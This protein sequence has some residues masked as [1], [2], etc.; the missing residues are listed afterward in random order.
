MSD[1]RY[2]PIKPAHVPLSQPAPSPEP[3]SHWRALPWVGISLLGL[4]SVALIVV[5]LL[6]RWI[7][8]NAP[9][10]E[11]GQ[12]TTTNPSNPAP[13]EPV[14]IP[15][16][17]AEQTAARREAQAVLTRLM[18]LRQDLENHGVVAWAAVP[19]EQAQALIADADQHYRQRG[20]VAALAQYQQAEQLL[21]QVQADQTTYLEQALEDGRS[22]L[23]AGEADA[24][25]R[26][27]ELALMM[28]PGN[29]DALQGQVRLERLPELLVALERAEEHE[30][31]GEL[32][33]ALTTFQEALALDSQSATAQQGRDRLRE[34]VTQQRYQTALDR[35]FAALQAGDDTSAQQAFREALAA[36]PGDDVARSGLA[37]AEDR[38]AH[39]Q[40]TAALQRARDLEQQESWAEAEQ[41]YAR[42]QQSDSSLVEARVG[43]MRAAARAQL[44][45]DIEQLLSDPL[46]LGSDA[47]LAHGRDVLANAR[48]LI[49]PGARLSRQVS[50]LENILQ[51]A[52]ATVSVALHSDN[53]TH[54]T[55]LRVADLGT[56]QTTQLELRP[57]RYVATGSRN[58]YRDVR[59]EFDVPLGGSAVTVEVICREPIGR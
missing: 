50:A 55:V 4:V 47:V 18:A 46:R 10:N 2:D 31:T 25:A 17:D 14:L 24:A 59:V 9:V 29:E 3:P 52:A 22:A 54:V 35:G 36:R 49:Q 5:F 12:G 27:F 8:P 51:Q 6:P 11:Q 16:D 15:Q 7:E 38:A 57:G 32:A 45:Q 48:A 33:A 23:E 28:D 13:E 20:F 56:L 37:Q 40:V 58:G 19:Y 26:H 43:Q 21:L 41:I 42:L 30:R 34:A 1:F 53:R 44:D 39:R